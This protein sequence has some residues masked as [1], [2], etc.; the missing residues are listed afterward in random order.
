MENQ[1]RRRARWTTRLAIAAA[2]ALA[3][4]SIASPA[5]ASATILPFTGGQGDAANLIF[6]VTNESPTASVSK[7]QLDL[8]SNPAIPEVYPLSTDNWA[9]QITVGNLVS[10]LVGVHGEQIDQTSASITWFAMP[11]QEMAPGKSIDLTISAGPFPAEKQMVFK[12]IV[13]NTDGTTVNYTQVPGA[14]ATSGEKPAIVVPLGP[15]VG[16]IDHAG[17]DAADTTGADADAA[18]DSAK[19][20]GGSPYNPWVLA[21]LLLLAGLTVFS[22]IRQR[23]ITTKST[24]GA[25]ESEEPV[26]ESDSPKELVAPSTKK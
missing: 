25:T 20:T 6:R 2:G 18:G 11:G 1:Q 4:L 5:S 22:L 23:R 14:A 7:I 10:P 8:P 15:G 12:V 19:S 16:T 26:N 17:H 9:P 21:V 13:T 24:V 3:L